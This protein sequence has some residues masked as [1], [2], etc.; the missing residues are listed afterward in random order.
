M[1]QKTLYERMSVHF[2]D[3]AQLRS[4]DDQHRHTDGGIASYLEALVTYAQFVL[5]VLPY[6]AKHVGEHL[7]DRATDAVIDKAVGS[8]T[9]FVERGLKRLSKKPSASFDFR[10]FD[11]TASRAD[12]F[13]DLFIQQSRLLDE[14][15]L[16]EAL[17]VGRKSA[18]KL[19][20][21]QF[22]IVGED[23]HRVTISMVIDIRREIRPAGDGGGA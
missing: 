19:L 9:E 14:S 20:S 15:G 16:E 1:T 2:H 5:P 12:K 8:A 18:Q 21:E 22:K 13:S 3:R 11:E 6:I 10:E 23:A 7:A 4:L 17:E